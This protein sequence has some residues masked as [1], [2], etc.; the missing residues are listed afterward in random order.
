MKVEIPSGSL[1]VLLS[2]GGDSVALLDLALRAGVDVSALHVN[3]GLREGA[4]QDEAFVRELCGSLGVP[5]F[6]ESVDLGSPGAGNLQERA[7]DARYA[8]AERLAAGLYGWRS[9]LDRARCT[10]CRR[11]AGAWCGRCWV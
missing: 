2:G 8:L 11:G 3:Y 9:R 5:L 4:D 6:A 10:G 7:R 1:L